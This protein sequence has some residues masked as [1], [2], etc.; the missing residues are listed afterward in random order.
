MVV[1][2]LATVIGVKQFYITS[3]FISLISSEFDHVLMFVG[4][5]GF[6]R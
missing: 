4:P 3:I 1:F 2:V 6:T 5:F